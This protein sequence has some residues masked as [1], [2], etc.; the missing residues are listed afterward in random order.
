MSLDVR[1]AGLVRASLRGQIDEGMTVNVG[2]SAGG[3]ALLH[4]M[5]KVADLILDEFLGVGPR[6]IRMRVVDLHH[7][8]VFSD[9]IEESVC[10]RIEEGGVPEATGENL[11][12]GQRI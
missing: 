3:E 9:D 5:I 4:V 8:P 1:L 10:G 12:G 2:G 7:H 11:V 6:G